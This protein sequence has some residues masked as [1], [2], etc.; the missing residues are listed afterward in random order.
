MVGLVGLLHC[1]TSVT[2]FYGG[3]SCDAHVMSFCFVMVGMVV[4]G[5]DLGWV[6]S[7]VYYIAPFSSDPLS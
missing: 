2:V 5:V 3:F 7:L 4:A 1:V 6:G